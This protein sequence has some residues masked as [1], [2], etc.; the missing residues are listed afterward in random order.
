MVLNFDNKQIATWLNL[1]SDSY[2]KDRNRL[3]KKLNLN[4]EEDTANYLKTL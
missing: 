4:P 2:K 1:T 3:R